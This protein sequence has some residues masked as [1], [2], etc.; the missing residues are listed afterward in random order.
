MRDASSTHAP[1]R[2]VRATVRPMRR[3]RVLRPATLV[4]LASACFVFTGCGVQMPADPDGTFTL[5]QDGTLRAGASIDGDLVRDDGGVLTGGAVSL[6]EKF[7]IEHGADLEWT[8]GSEES[9]VGALEAGNLQIVVGGMSSASPWSERAGVTRP[10][11]V[12]PGAD[13]RDIVMLVPLGENRLL[14]EL[15][16]FLDQEV[17]R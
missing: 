9:L 5:M 8:I 17:G 14:F 13:G 1:D 7:A 6:V 4:V 11:D 10:Y 15:E 3:V 2:L 16:S 12:I